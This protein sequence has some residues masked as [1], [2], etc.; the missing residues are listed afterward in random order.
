MHHHTRAVIFDMDG[1]IIDSEPLWRQAMVIGFQEFGLQFTEH[2]CRKTTGMR[3]KEVILYWQ[4]FYPEQLTNPDAVHHAII[5]K[6]INLINSQG[7]AMPGL[8]ELLPH[9]KSKQIKIGLSTSS[10]QILIEAI[11]NKLEIKHFF[12]AIVSAQHLRYGKPH[13]EVYLECA[14]QLEVHPMDCLV[15][16]DSV[17]GMISA[18][19]AQ[20]HVLAIPDAEHL[21][22]V[23]FQAAD[24]I[25]KHLSE[26][27]NYILKN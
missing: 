22:N 24:A 9:L 26:V 20:M 6:L 15:I 4:T 10:D 1:V 11:L 3:L 13:P 14:K 23:K 8:T 21:N 12:N 5:N 7:T 25:I 16:E 18:L 19:A 27:K 17:N 2:D